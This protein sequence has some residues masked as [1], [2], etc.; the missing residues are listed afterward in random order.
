M[1]EIGG[2]QPI[3]KHQVLWGLTIDVTIAAFE[4]FDFILLVFEHLLESPVRSLQNPDFLFQPAILDLKF[5]FLDP[6]RHRVWLPFRFYVCECTIFRCLRKRRPNWEIK[7]VPPF[8][9]NAHNLESQIIAVHFDVS[10]LLRRQE[11]KEVF[12]FFALLFHLLRQCFFKE[13]AFCDFRSM[14]LDGFDVH[15][16]WKVGEEEVMGMR[17]NRE[18]FLRRLRV[19]LIKL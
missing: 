9:F 3:F 17:V 1:L 4:F 19:H 6:R 2:I 8:L 15:V 12:H 7:T 18:V 11:I 5:L 10:L 16:F 14:F 13:I